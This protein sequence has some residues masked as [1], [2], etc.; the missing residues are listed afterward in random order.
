MVSLEK[1]RSA[2]IKVKMKIN[3]IARE[4]ESDEEPPAEAASQW[5]NGT[6]VAASASKQLAADLE[7]KAKQLEKANSK[8]QLVEKKCAALES[9]LRTT[10]K[11][12]RD[13]TPSQSEND[14]DQNPEKRS[15]P[16]AERG[17]Y[18]SVILKPVRHFE[19]CG[20]R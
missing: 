19:P 5:T 15:P 13:K 18:R 9:K 20:L 14:K 12:A 17:A 2:S 7:K 16:N 11:R 4:Q 3:Q 6:S 1:A 10:K 8:L